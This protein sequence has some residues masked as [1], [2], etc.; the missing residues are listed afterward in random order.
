MDALMILSVL[1]SSALVMFGSAIYYRRLL[2]PYIPNIQKMPEP[3]S[4]KLSKKCA[5]NAGKNRQNKTKKNV[6][7]HKSKTAPKCDGP[8][9]QRPSSSVSTPEHS[10]KAN[11]PTQPIP[12]EPKEAKANKIE[13]SKPSE[14][15]KP[16]TCEIR[17]HKTNKS[18]QVSVMTSNTNRCLNTL[19]PEKEVCT[20]LRDGKPFATKFNEPGPSKDQIS[21]AERAPPK[22]EN[23]EHTTVLTYVP[24]SEIIHIMGKGGEIIK[25]LEAKHGVKIY[26]SY[27]KDNEKVIK[28]SGANA[29]VRKEVEYNIRD[30]MSMTVSLPNVDPALYTQIKNQVDLGRLRILH[31]NT[32]EDETRSITFTGIARYCKGILHYSS[33]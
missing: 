32:T 3:E 20:K 31:I 22:Q 30:M 28:I 17:Q 27:H 14:S 18:K 7:K 6:E 25:H 9:S 10:T 21:F 19:E 23:S 24:D 13:Q 5:R 26:S 1:L 15:A 8:I 11:K 12:S 16:E 4:S 2:S 29:L 33:L